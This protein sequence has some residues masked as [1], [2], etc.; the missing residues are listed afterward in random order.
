MTRA[1]LACLLLAGC[2]GQAIVDGSARAGSGGATATIGAGGADAGTVKPGLVAPD[3]SF[4]VVDRNDVPISGAIVVVD[5]AGGVEEQRTTHQD[6]VAMFSDVDF[7]N[8]TVDVTVF[9]PGRILVT[10]LGV[11]PTSSRVL[12]LQPRR[13]SAGWTRTLTVKIRNKASSSDCITVGLTTP[14]AHVATCGESTQ[15]DTVTL[16]TT[17]GSSG[18]IIAEDLVPHVGTCPSLAAEFVADIPDSSDTIDVDFAKAQPIQVAS[19]TLPVPDP[20]EGCTVGPTT[21]SVEARSDVVAFLKN[22]QP[23]QNGVCH[24]NTQ[25]VPA[26]SESEVETDYSS[27]YGPSHVGVYRRGNFPA[28]ALPR[29]PDPIVFAV[30]PMVVSLFDPIQWTAGSDLPDR[31]HVWADDDSG[32]IFRVWTIWFP[33]EPHGV[34][35]RKPPDSIWTQLDWTHQQGLPVSVEYCDPGPGQCGGRPCTPTEEPW[36]ERYVRAFSFDFPAP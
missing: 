19:G 10:V 9:S 31:L 14:S 15:P 2:G 8:E 21:R 36:C 25:Y 30:A 34:K 22:V 18:K 32:R 4:L 26:F 28:T 12:H 33:P 5:R 27:W 16:K 24:W 35:L 20:T 17:P 29:L 11:S 23:V 13:S 1:A 7:A 6:G 3:G